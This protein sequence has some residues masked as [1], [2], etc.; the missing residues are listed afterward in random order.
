MNNDKKLLDSLTYEDLDE[1]EIFRE[2]EIKVK[3]V[4]TE[5]FESAENAMMPKPRHRK[6]K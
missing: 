2:P 6:R 3:K 4:E 1:I 5:M